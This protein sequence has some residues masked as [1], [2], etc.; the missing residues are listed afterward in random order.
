MTEPSGNV[1]RVR[2]HKDGPEFSAV[3]WG[4]M[5]SEEQFTS[6]HELAEFLRFLLDRGVTTLDTANTY[7]FPDPYTVEEFLGKALKET[8]LRDRF[9][10]VTKCGIQRVSPHRTVNR[11]RHYDFTETEIRRS[12]DRSLNKL[13]VDHVDLVL[14]HRPD[15]LMDPEETAGALDALI[16]EGKTRHVGVSNMSPSR[17]HLLA[18]KLKAPIVTNQVEFSPIHLDP[19]SDGTFDTALIEGHRPMIWSPIGGG[20]LMTGDDPYVATI[21]DILTAIAERNG[22]A[23]PA[24]AAIAFVVR[25]PAGG[26]PIIGSGKRER[27]EAAIKAV[28]NPLDRQDWYEVVTATS[29]MLEL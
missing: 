25:H 24:E 12:I 1:A 9:E 8:G 6:P 16:A 14:L 18:S 2:L 7:G 23:G 19:I 5:R 29:A 15:Y 21:R 4:S 10:I 28:N 20:R 3:I 13:G 27:L 17:Y 26:I 11:I 22:L